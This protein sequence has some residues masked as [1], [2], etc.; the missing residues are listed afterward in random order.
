MK[1]F[2]SLRL[3]FAG[4][5]CAIFVTAGLQARAATANPAANAS[6]STQKVVFAGGCFWGIE[7]VFESLKGVTSAV[8]GY[9]GGSAATAHYDIVSTGTTGHAESVEVTFDPAQIS[10]QQLLEVFFL[11]AHDPT[12]LNRQGPDDGTQYRSVVFYTSE[13]QKR[14]VQSYIA[15]LTKQKTFG[16]P[17]VTQVVPLVAFYPA[18]A[19]HQHFASHNPYNP[20]IMINDAPKLVHL[21]QQFP[22]LVKSSS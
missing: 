2:Q 1:L 4:S 19:Y 3:L 20:Y 17:I 22:T 7:A 8:S 11:V 10:F 12:E 5:L 9:S 18:E 14:D 16:A 21:H 6:A 13:E 15:Q